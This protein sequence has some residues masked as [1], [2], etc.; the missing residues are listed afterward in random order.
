MNI[1]GP[2]GLHALKE[3]RIIDLSTGNIEWHSDSY[4]SNHYVW[5]DD[6]KFVAAQYSG[7]Q[8]TETLVLDTS[9]FSIIKLPGIDDILKAAPD[10][11]APNLNIPMSQFTVIGWESSSVIVIRFEWITTSDTTVVGE[12]K[13]NVVFW[14]MEVKK[15]DEIKT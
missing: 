15:I 10:T 2:S 13:Y 3:M 5:S 4:L 11:P 8:W 12:Y 14:E 9:D 7:R 6:S 1:D